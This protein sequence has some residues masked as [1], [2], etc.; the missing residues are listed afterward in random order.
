V[1]ACHMPTIGLPLTGKSLLILDCLH[2]HH[3]LFNDWYRLLAAILVNRSVLLL[4]HEKGNGMMTREKMIQQF[5]AVGLSVAILAVVP[6][7]AT[8]ASPE[9]S[10]NRE[11]WIAVADHLIQTPPE[12]YPYDWGEATLFIG[13]LKAYE[14]THNVAYIDYAE[15]WAALYTTKSREEL[16]ELDASGSHRDESGEGVGP[17]PGDCNRW[18]PGTVMLSLF[19]ERN[20][21]DYRRMVR[22]ITDFIRE[23]AERSPEGGLDHWTGSHE[24]WVDTLY[25]ACPLLARFGKMEN[26]PA[27]VDD[28]AQQF[29]L[30]A[31]DLQDEKTGLF[32]H[33]WDWQTGQLTP[34]LW[35]RGNGWVLMALADSMEMMD[36][37]HTS[38]ASLQQIT[39]R[40]AHGLRSV[41]DRDGLWHTVLNDPTSYSECSASSMFVYGFLKLVRLKVLPR[42]YKKVALRGW[43]AIN[44]R[45]VKDGVVTGVSGSTDPHPVEVY[46]KIEVGTETWGTGAYLSA[47]SEVDRLH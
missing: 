34:V 11:K 7:A 9:A 1:K 4:K 42:S 23:S 39:L 18:V 43:A 47:G 12:D 29:I 27:Y 40:L 24:Y 26:K 6:I 33:M 8:A 15:K 46:K 2:V 41:Q 19:Q 3:F 20:K 21:Q 35:G 45:Y 25:M 37:T 16:L 44:A 31:R 5:A 10:L 30:H 36:R 22:M 14:R 13:L 38:F 17:I 28:A 32:Y